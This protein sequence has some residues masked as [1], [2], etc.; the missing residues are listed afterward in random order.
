MGYIFDTNIF[1]R[2]KIE[3]PSDLWPTFWAR[4]SELIRNGRITSSVKVKEEIERGN[5]DLTEWMRNNTT[6]VFF[7]PIDAEVLEKYSD[8]QNWANTN[9]IFSQNARTEYANV[10]DAYL[11]ATAAA[12]GMTLV[13]YETRDP[14]C[15][16]RVK[17]PDACIALGVRYC[18]LNTAL[19]ELGVTI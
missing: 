15:R 18:D 6:P 8:T 12:K 4:M 11:V 14:M 16:R 17:I 19:R 10:A 7:L 13:T 2:S 1:I 9:P 5:D 3:M